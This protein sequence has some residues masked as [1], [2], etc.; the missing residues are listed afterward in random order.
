[1][2]YT[3]D[4]INKIT[5]AH[6]N[7]ENFTEQMIFD[8]HFDVAGDHATNALRNAKKFCPSCKGAWTSTETMW[9][10]K[11]R[12]EVALMSYEADLDQVD[13][14]VLAVILVLA[15]TRYI[16]AIKMLRDRYPHLS[17]F[18]AKAIVQRCS[19]EEVITYEVTRA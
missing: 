2:N 6:Y 11:Y 1:M 19:V 10:H 4:Q 17:L 13:D 18:T 12:N 8:H 9:D 5:T 7:I 15:K 14:E 3:Q 16:T